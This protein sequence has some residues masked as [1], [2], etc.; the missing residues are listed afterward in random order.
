MWLWFQVAV[1]HG[2]TGLLFSRRLLLPPGLISATLG[3][4]MC[5]AV[6]SL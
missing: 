4:V 5:A 3:T 6:L 2:V 1:P